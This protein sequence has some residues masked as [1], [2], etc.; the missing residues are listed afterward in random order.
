ML[1]GRLFAVASICLAAGAGAAEAGDR[2]CGSRELVNTLA[3]LGPALF[4]CWVPPAGTD[5]KELTLTFSVR[6]NG[7]IIGK[8]RTS[9]S[10]SIAGSDLDK[11][12]VASIL[13]ALDKALPLPLTESFGGVIAGQPM[14]LRF[15]AEVGTPL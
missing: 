5:G 12:F 3:D 9:Y 7:T 1:T 14:A 8:P 13:E 15:V 4:A 6:R 2:R 11:A 10:K